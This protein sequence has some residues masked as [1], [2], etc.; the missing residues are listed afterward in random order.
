MTEERPNFEVKN[1]ADGTISRRKFLRKA[2]IGIGGAA[3]LGVGLK[4]GL[5]EKTTP[6]KIN[7]PE[8][9]PE[10][11]KRKI[12]G[13][14][15]YFKETYGIT[16]EAGATITKYDGTETSIPAGDLKPEEVLNGME[17]IK[18]ELLKYPPDLIKEWVHITSIRL[19]KNLMAS[20][21]QYEEKQDPSNPQSYS[22]SQKD[23][24]DVAFAFRINDAGKIKLQYNGA[25]FSDRNEVLKNMP[26]KLH[27]MILELAVM[28]SLSLEGISED[29]FRMQQRSMIQKMSLEMATKG[30]LNDKFWEDLKTGKVDENYL[31]TQPQ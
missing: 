23:R 12:T 30:K 1:D 25:E 13:N 7:T 31:E 20:P 14:K 11:L 28:K 3:A 29:K 10:E 26:E 27:Q 18:S 5:K 6:I 9:S 22:I 2:A 19:V 17:A 8:I 21:N 15:S 4:L 16:I 24:Y